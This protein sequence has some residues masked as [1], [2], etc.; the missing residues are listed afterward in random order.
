MLE[1]L[2]RD[3]L[4][5]SGTVVEIHGH[6]DNQGN[7]IRNMALSEARAFAVKKWL[8]Q[9][10]P[11]TSR[12]GASASSRTARKT[13]RGKRDAA[14]PRP[15]PPRGNRIGNRRVNSLNAQPLLPK[16]LGEGRGAYVHA[17]T[18]N[19]QIVNV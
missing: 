18:M 15:E 19:E 13:R 4:V 16:S 7:A 6:T 14:G 8:E 11:V 1:Q 17:Y 10:Y 12:Q 9:Q 5:A 2:G 3:A